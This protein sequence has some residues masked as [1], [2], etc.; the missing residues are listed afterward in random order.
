M[1][2]SQKYYILEKTERGTEKVSFTVYVE[3][4]ESN[5]EK[6]CKDIAVIGIGVDIPKA[7]SAEQFWNLLT[8]SITTGSDIPEG[9]KE[10]AEKYFAKISGNMEKRNYFQGSYL[11][12][13]DQ[14]DYSFFGISKK[15]SDLMDPAQRIFME[16]AW[17][18]LDDAGY[19]G[20]S[21]RNA[22]VGVFAGCSNSNQYQNI[23]H[24]SEDNF[25]MLS[26]TGNL[27]SIV[28]S[29]ISYYMDFKGPSM[30][31]DT[32]CS[33][34]LV[35]V[36]LA[37]QSIQNQE[38]VY[39]LAG[40]VNICVLPVK[41]EDD[42]GIE[43]S[44][45]QTRTFDDSSDG[46]M[47]GEGA[48]VIL[49]K[50]LSQAIEDRDSIYAVIKG[51]AINQDGA[52]AGITAPNVESQKNVIVSAWERAEINPEELA[53][54]EA[55]GTGT[56]LGDPIEIDAMVKAF[57]EYT[58]KKQFCAVGSVKT[59]IGHLDY[60]SGIAGLIKVVLMLKKHCIPPNL[61]F[62]MP[63]RKIP[64]EKSPVYVN[65]RCIPW[66]KNGIMKC[67]VSSFG[68]SGT[69]CHIIL[70]E[71]V[72]EK[73]LCQVDKP[74]LLVLSS[75]SY[76]GLLTAVEQIQTAM[77]KTASLENICYTLAVGRRHSTYRLAIVFENKLELMESLE[78]YKMG[79]Q[80][81]K[82]ILYG[83]AIVKEIFSDKM[84]I[85][86]NTIQS[87]N[88]ESLYM[89]AQQYITGEKIDWEWMYMYDKFG[90]VHLAGTVFQKQKCWPEIK[91]GKRMEAGEP[92]KHPLF[93]VCAVKSLFQDIYCTYFSLNK[94]WVVKDHHF[95]GKYFPP[96]TAYL[97]MMLYLGT[98][99][100]KAQPFNLKKIMFLKPMEL[101]TD[102]I[103]KVHSIVEKKESFYAVTITGYDEENDS[104]DVYAKCELCSREQEIENT[105]DVEAIRS[106]LT[107]ITGK[108][109]NNPVSIENTIEFGK[110]W[111]SIQSE[112]YCN[113]E[114]LLIKSVMP[115]N[116]KEDFVEYLCHPALLDVSINTMSHSM[117]NG[118]YLPLA[119]DTFELYD[120]VPDKIYCYIKKC[121]ATEDKELVSF[122][123][124]LL[125]MT[126][127]LIGSI[128]RHTIKRL[129]EEDLHSNVPEGKTEKQ[130]EWFYQVDWVEDKKVSTND[131][132]DK[133]TVL[134]I[135]NGTKESMQLADKFEKM[136]KKVWRI[137]TDC[138]EEET[139]E[140]RMIQLAK[141]DI[142]SLDIVFCD[143]LGTCSC[144]ESIQQVEENTES[145]VFRFHRILRILSQQEN[146]RKV[147]IT[148]VTDQAERITGK[149]DFNSPY[150]KMRQGFVRAAALEY[151][152]SQFCCI[153][154]EHGM[155]L[156]QAVQKILDLADGEYIAIRDGKC[157]VR[158]FKK[159]EYQ[160]N[161]NPYPLK[162][163]GVYLITGG[164][165][166][167]GFEIS[168]E[169]LTRTNSKLVLIG[170]TPIHTTKENY[171][172]RGKD[173]KAERLKKLQ[174][175][176]SEVSYFESDVADL[177]CMKK[178]KE[179]ILDR[180]GKI[181]GIIHGAGIM[182]EGFLYEKTEEG[183]W[184]TIRPK[185]MGSWILHK[186]FDE[187]TLD[188]ILYMSSITSILGAPGQADYTAANVFLD[189]VWEWKEKQGLPVHI[190]NWST[191]KETGMAF[192]NHVKESGML[193]MM[194][195][196][197][198]IEAFHKYMT[199]HINNAIIG[200]IRK[201]LGTQNVEAI[202]LQIEESILHSF[203]Q[204]DEP[205]NVEEVF[206]K[207]DYE[208]I[209]N[210][211][212]AV[213]CQ[214]LGEKTIQDNTTFS[215][216]GGNSLI[217]TK[218]LKELDKRYP[219]KLDITDI[220]TYPS[221]R[222]ISGYISEQ[223]EK[224]RKVNDKQT[225]QDGLDILD[226][227]LEQL[228]EGKISPESVDELLKK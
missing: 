117:G 94:H 50:S 209:L 64:F 80:T 200:K 176:S 129:H 210:N 92:V 21:L 214:V 149:E 75:G 212:R 228:A 93:D 136:V 60:A 105:E 13:V 5:M 225:N 112:I 65:D 39:A 37:C 186:L 145:A 163:Q 41:K 24:A 76:E 196:S 15:E 82:N 188:F 68:L 70:E 216:L 130:T 1:D 139:L 172:D 74:G 72:Q 19:G 151:R 157:Y 95:M 83:K 192:E 204:R 56:Q 140:E 179:K 57:L 100:Y 155:E 40:G 131:G 25:A 141:E 78:Q 124:K 174:E 53:Y 126:G 137:R 187:R 217:A 143:L 205:I 55:H 121:D 193:E 32:A 138:K 8:K 7:K 102:E 29:R 47:Y 35:S 183:M 12:N 226:Q 167:M 96:G 168:K 156:E 61:H 119:Q 10:D 90:R 52:S 161:E 84:P 111:T 211:V 175:L 101:Q 178:V 115:D 220:F 160:R 158:R 69:N 20:D 147:K 162:E 146:F 44:V 133:K 181:N 31:I 135:E 107:K 79:N 18:C 134:V 118:Y 87:R 165:G 142:E 59:N 206:A 33:S 22:K 166:G 77:E 49:L 26:F 219:R 81:R 58:E 127:K 106:R 103:K 43:S 91:E 197:H 104:W 201:N 159:A 88:I 125:S 11:D 45:N 173:L 215:K 42:Y 67:G 207:T 203:T 86:S 221:I 195:T 14:F 98:Q 218:L 177:Q 222:Q 63:N 148:S 128:R 9:R 38:C 116:Y 73:I 23:I 28:A 66:N 223:Y 51:S 144:C 132:Y 184:K 153:D 169:I 108:Q 114:E 46:T 99:Y 164:L 54:I 62:N 194:T 2:G 202:N 89:I 180:Y 150:Q 171:P 3:D 170:R 120:R 48:G 199:Y 227:V 213:W 109:M 27:R 36:H 85:Y 17:K 113:D 71:H 4:N 122:D 123:I 182:S 191:W 185:V 198:A 152:T 110:H 189:G 6:K 224:D 190:I 154:L 16:T 208:S 34:S 97:E 30:V